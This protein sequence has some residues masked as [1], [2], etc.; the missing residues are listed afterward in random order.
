MSDDSNGILNGCEFTM[1]RI[2][3]LADFLVGNSRQ[4]INVILIAI[5][6]E[7]RFVQAG[8]RASESSLKGGQDRNQSA[9]PAISNDCGNFKISASA[10]VL[11]QLSPRMLRLVLPLPLLR[12]F[13]RKT[14]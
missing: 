14:D 10:N 8:S 11:R 12:F 4:N 9:S 5:G 6:F 13:G 3:S 7:R 2:V 1:L